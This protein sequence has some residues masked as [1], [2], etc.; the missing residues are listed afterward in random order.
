MKDYGLGKLYK[1][2]DNKSMHRLP[3]YIYPFRYKDIEG[4]K[5]DVFVFEEDSFFYQD[6]Q[7]WMSA[8]TLRRYYEVVDDKV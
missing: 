2:K 5:Y 7:S 6:G 4:E 1:L 8:N 3:S